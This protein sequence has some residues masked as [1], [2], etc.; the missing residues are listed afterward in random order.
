MEQSKIIET[1]ETCQGAIAVVCRRQDGHYL[2]ASAMVLA[3]HAWREALALAED[4]HVNKITIANDCLRVVNELRD[5]TFLGPYGMILR[6]I[7]KRATFF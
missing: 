7:S 6:D 4:L 1:L 2:G 3:G 5:H